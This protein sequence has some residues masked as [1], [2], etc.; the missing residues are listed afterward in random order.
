MARPPINGI[1]CIKEFRNIKVIMT[2]YLELYRE[3]VKVDIPSNIGIYEDCSYWI[4]THEEPGVIYVESPVEKVFRLGDFFAIWG[5][6]ISSDSFMGEKVTSDKP[7]KIYVDGEPY[8][9]DPRDIVLKD[10]MKITIYY[11][12]VES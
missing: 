3:G 11:G 2:V 1:E 7:L 9:G 6:D 5:V 10:G 8:N 12:K 4:H